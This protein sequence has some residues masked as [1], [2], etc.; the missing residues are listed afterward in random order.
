MATIVYAPWAYGCTTP[1]PT[2]WLDGLMAATTLLWAYSTIA[3]R[4]NLNFPRVLV[5]GACWLFAQG[6]I[7]ALNAHFLYNPLT[8]MFRPNPSGLSFLPGAADTKLVCKA[9]LHYSSLLGILFVATDLLEDVRWRVRTFYT[10][11]LTGISIVLL[12]LAQKLSGARTVF[13]EHDPVSF[14]FFATYLYHGNAAS[15][16][17]LVLPFLV[18][19]A[20]MTLRNRELVQAWGFWVPATMLCLDSAFV[21]ISK[22]G[23]VIAILLMALACWGFA[24]LGG[25]AVWIFFKKNRIIPLAVSF[26]IV[27]PIAILLCSG[28]LMYRWHQLFRQFG[29]DYPRLLTAQ[30]CLAIIP[31]SGIFGF[32]PG[33]FVEI[34]PH[35]TNHLGSQIK[36]IWIH[37]HNDYLEMLI[38][39]GW[40]GAF[41][42]GAIVFG[43]VIRAARQLLQRRVESSTQDKIFLF[44]MLLALTGVLVHAAIDLPLETPSLQFYITIMVG[45]CW[46]SP[47][48]LRTRLKAK[49]RELL[50]ASV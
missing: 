3:G 22:A 21:N 2:S 12:G 47:R 42:W 24:Y 25:R 44:C 14:T 11:S 19:G 36:G 7:M 27:V 39:W 29:W 20:V 16:L 35:F 41:A 32:G 15:Y 49:R 31:K 26:A 34:F 40:I 30:T 13:W 50:V 10:I 8:Q 38:E 46:N 37:A 33:T 28:T 5:I 4:R 48:W 9:M 17:N 45:A 6:W 43:G 18:G 1:G 23:M